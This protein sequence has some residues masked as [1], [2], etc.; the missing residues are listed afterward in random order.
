[1]I[2]H[3]KWI[4]QSEMVFPDKGYCFFSFDLSTI[5]HHYTGNWH[6]H[7]FDERLCPIKK[8]MT[9]GNE[10]VYDLDSTFI[11]TSV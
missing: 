4:S 2:L 10:H 1:M 11:S 6:R 7:S 5:N 9:H 8:T 3:E